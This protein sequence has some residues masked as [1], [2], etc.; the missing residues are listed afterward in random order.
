MNRRNQQ[1]VGFVVMLVGVS[2]VGQALAVREADAKPDREIV[3]EQYLLM[4]DATRGSGESQIAINPLNPNEIAVAAMGVLNQNDGRFEHNELEFQRTPRATLTR[5][6]VS[7]DR[8]LTWTVFEDP[9]RSYFHRY[10]CLDPFA[11]FTPDGTMIL[12]CEAHFPTN[13]GEAE[14][15]DAVNGSKM[16]YGG[17]TIIWSTDGGRTFSDPVQ[18]ISTYMP[19]ELYGP[20]VSFAGTGATGDAPKIKIDASN[21]K[22]YIDGNSPAATPPHSQTIVRMSKDKGRDW[23]VVYAFDAPDWP[24]SGATFD[25][26]QGMIGAVYVASQVP[27]ELGAKC[28]CRVIGVSTDDGKTFERHLIPVPAGPSGPGSGRDMFL[29]AD[30]TKVGRFALMIATPTQVDAYLTEDA[31]KTWSTPTHLGAIP[32]TR[33]EALAAQ[34]N[35]KGVLGV[36]WLVMFPDPKNPTARGGGPPGGRGGP[37]HVFA[38]APESFENWSAIS[39]DGGKTW[40]AA[41]EVSTARSP[42]QPRRRGNSSHSADFTSLAMDDDFVHMTWFDARAGFLGTWYGRVPISD[43]K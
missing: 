29:A 3:A 5:F 39:R 9:M 1:L 15:I 31:G 19:K 26:A 41:L 27:I 23:G 36:S 11:A 28:P 37:V 7:R 8:G 12:G 30:P 14:Q 25:V 6:A 20:F 4:G 35:G 34:Y 38:A 21:G 43:Y 33:V 42:G 32:G 13:L 18:V 16:N 40:S 17:S 22:I 24:G 2:A 10:R